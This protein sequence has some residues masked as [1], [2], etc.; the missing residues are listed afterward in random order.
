MVAITFNPEREIS[1]IWSQR[2]GASHKGNHGRV[3]VVGGSPAYGGAPILASMGVLRGGG[4]L[5]T[6]AA[7]EAIVESANAHFPDIIGSP[8]SGL[9][10]KSR[11]VSNIRSLARENDVVLVGN[12]AGEQS[13]P[14]LKKLIP[15][16]VKDNAKLVLDAHAFHAM[17]G[18]KMGLRNCICL[19][20][21]KEFELW[22]KQ[23]VRALSMPAR[24]TLLQQMIGERD[25]VINLK[26]WK[27]VIVSPHY[28]YI[29][30]TGNPGM[31]KGG[32]GDVLAG[33]TASFWAQ[34]MGAFASA[35][36]AAWLNGKCADA[37]KSKKW[38][39]YIA[40]DIGEEVNEM[41]R[42]FKTGRLKGRK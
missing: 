19:P 23:D 37:L 38:F 8:L 29:N 35:A 7:P 36:C 31:T 39:G 26:D 11:H 3:L 30:S 42:T 40:R 6:L 24:V 1:Q 34:G 13:L 14:A 9:Y 10:I 21:V 20:H 15:L 16:L 17:R 4:D 27:S 5:V 2:K 32:F 22:T 41:K 28:S 25:M 12:G 18:G 33:F